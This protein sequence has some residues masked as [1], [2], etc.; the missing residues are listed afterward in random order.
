MA[1]VLLYK[2]LREVGRFGRKVRLQGFVI[3]GE[4]LLPRGK[5]RVKGENY[6]KR[7]HWW[8]KATFK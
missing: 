7:L 8:R 6:N 1:K 5:R 4:W 2:V 3:I